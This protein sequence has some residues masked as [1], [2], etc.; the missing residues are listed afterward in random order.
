MPD[1]DMAPKPDVETD[2]PSTDATTLL[3]RIDTLEAENEQLKAEVADSHGAPSGRSR[4]AG[5]ISLAVVA[6]LLMALSVPAVWL[7]RMLTDTDAYVATVAPLAHDPDIQNAVAT[8][9]SQAVVEKLDAQSRIDQLLPDNLSFIAAPVAQAVNGF[10]EKEAFVL[11]RSDRFAK[12]WETVNRASHKALVTAVTGRDTGAVGVKAGVITLDV[13]ALADQLK[14]RLTDSGLGFAAG[15][16][17]AGIS[18]QIVLFES[19]ALARLSVAFDLFARIALWLPLLGLAFAVAAV[20]LAADPRIAILW[21]GGAL[22]IGA[23]LPLQTLFL[24]QTY[25]AGQLSQL[26]SIPT[27]AAQ[28]AFSIIFR[29]LITADRAMTALGVALWL[30]AILAGPATWAVAMRTGMSGGLSGVASHLELG[31]FGIWVRAR[32]GTLR[33]VGAGI[34]FLILMVLPAPRTV[35]SI[36]WLTSFW[37]LW[38]LVVELLGAEPVATKEVAVAPTLPTE[39]AER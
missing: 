24:G 20:G 5:A 22:A 32:K 18:K 19:P 34:A 2:A 1:T 17:T 35:A 31:R 4:N 16:P 10:I 39:P 3:A 36:V 33:W 14:A 37:V 15:I 7:N 38:L 29:D 6:A 23:I 11:V 25:V 26:A 27:P 12:T 9:A 28:A 13:G 30:G 8:A 21:L